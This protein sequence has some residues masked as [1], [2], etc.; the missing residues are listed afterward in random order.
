MPI[1]GPRPLD[2]E[3]AETAYCRVFFY[4][5]KIIAADL[6]L[7]ESDD[8]T[9]RAILGAVVAL[10]VLLEAHPEFGFHCH[11]SDFAG[12]KSRYL[13]WF[14]ANAA[15]LQRTAAARRK[16]R[17][18]AEAEFDRILQLCDGKGYDFREWIAESG[19]RKADLRSFGK[20]GKLVRIPPL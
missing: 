14:D 4:L 16:M 6:Q 12:W 1:N 17:K 7:A 2:S 15:R 5:E 18:L 13:A 3:N 10:R 11:A 19:D 9:D 20:D 8:R